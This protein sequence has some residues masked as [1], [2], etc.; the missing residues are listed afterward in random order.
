MKFTKQAIDAIPPGS[1]SGT[2]YLDDE[3][4]GFFLVSWVSGRKAFFVRY[5]GPDGRRRAVKIGYYGDPLTLDAARKKAKTYLAKVTLGGNPAEDRD[6]ARKAVTWKE[7]TATYFRRIENRKKDKRSDRRFLCVPGNK[8]GKLMKDW[9][10]RPLA[11][12]SREDVAVARDRIAK[13][14]PIVANRWHASV[15]ACLTAAERSGYIVGNPAKGLLML[16]ENPPRR[17]FL[18]NDEMFALLTSLG[19]ESDYFG[20][21]ALRLMI[22]TG[23]R[24]S[25]ALR[26]R[27]EDIDFGT[28]PPQW[29]IPSPK[30]GTPQFVGLGPSTAALL[31]SLPRTGPLVAPALRKKGPRANLRTLWERVVTGAGLVAGRKENGIT[32]H[33]V[34]RTMGRH[35]AMQFGLHI[36]KEVLRHSSIRVTEAAYAPLMLSEVSAAVS[37]RNATRI[38]PSLPPLPALPAQVVAAKKRTAK[39]KK[40]SKR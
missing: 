14:A 38:V 32:V 19:K 12:I 16:P 2:W 15:R 20:V 1:E 34:R 30:S 35:I 5:T 28:T 18:S 39:D 10:N 9:Q 13:T 6:A 4:R 23:C 29:R 8:Y 3:L 24:Q 33:D 26:A 21:V 27:W 17:R 7:W 31:E 11:A 40:P 36:A 37:E 22:E 25:E